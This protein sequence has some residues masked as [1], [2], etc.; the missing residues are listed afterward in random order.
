MWYGNKREV[1]SYM[2][3]SDMNTGGYRYWYKSETINVGL[4]FEGVCD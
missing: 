3:R 2:E 1:S 4:V